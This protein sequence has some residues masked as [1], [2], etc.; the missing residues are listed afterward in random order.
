MPKEIKK[1]VIEPD[2]T[3]ATGP[4]YNISNGCYRYSNVFEVDPES[5]PII[6]KH[7]PKVRVYIQL[8]Q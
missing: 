8:P 4:E 5:V 1:E 2:K 7:Y 3:E 6:K